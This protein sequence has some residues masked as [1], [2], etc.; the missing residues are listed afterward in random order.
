MQLK[1][2]ATRT[3]GS[4]LFGLAVLFPISSRADTLYTFDIPKSQLST[5]KDAILALISGQV[6]PDK[7]GQCHGIADDGDIHF[8]ID[9]GSLKTPAVCEIMNCKAFPPST[10]SPAT[11]EGILQPLFAG[12]PFISVRGVF[13]VWSDHPNNSNPPH[14]SNPG[15]VVEIHP[16]T[17]VIGQSN[18][19]HSRRNIA[20]IEFQGGIFS[21]KNPSQWSTMLAKKMYA[22]EVTIDGKKLI[23]IRTPLVGYNYWKIT[24]RIVTAPTAVTN[25]HRF[26]VNI[27]TPTGVLAEEVR[28]FTVSESPADSDV[29]TFMSGD[30]ATLL[31]IG[32]IDLRKLLSSLPYE[33]PT[34]VELCVF[35]VS[36]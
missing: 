9:S 31:A 12:S 20:P 16:V 30:E 7:L 21:Y 6:A 3:L 34:P 4:L 19:Y 23:R 11:W 25:G 15:H 33:G 27:K 36:L 8:G 29:T 17:A 13:R 35:G 32:R 14:A 22:S 5:R 2:S 24:A 10:A 28:C 18:T 26:T 1:H